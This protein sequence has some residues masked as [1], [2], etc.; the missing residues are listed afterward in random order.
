LAPKP[1]RTLLAGRVL[2]FNPATSVFLNCPYDLDYRPLFDASVLATVCCGFTPRIASDTGTVAEPRTARIAKAIFESKYSVHDLSRC[3]GEGDANFARFNMPLELGMAIARRYFS[4]R[5]SDRHDWMAMVP[6]GHAY[7]RYI[8]D[9]AGFD[10]AVHD[11]TDSGLIFALMPWLV[12]RVG[13]QGTLSP[14]RVVAA[15]PRFS[16]E[17]RLLRK[18]WGNWPPWADVIL[19]AQKIAGKISQ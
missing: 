19:A 17:M 5:L 12:T 7:G 8:S 18:T 14:Q 15:L 4:R 10:P 2:T 16:R 9:L 1:G 6:S 11:S 13:A 3:K